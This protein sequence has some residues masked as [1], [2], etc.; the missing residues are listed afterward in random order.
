MVT[1]SSILSWRI[2]RTEEPGGLQSIGS[3]RVRHDWETD[4]GWISLT[5][6]CACHIVVHIRNCLGWQVSDS[7]QPQQSSHTCDLLGAMVLKCKSQV[8][9]KQPRNDSFV[10]KTQAVQRTFPNA[11]L[12]ILSYS[13]KETSYFNQPWVWVIWGTQKAVCVWLRSASVLC[14]ACLRGFHT[15]RAWLTPC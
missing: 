15:L 9:Q 1:H 14:F 6:G 10:L 4:R 2:P 12:I 5:S 11:L 7:G 3:Q 13:R 8:L